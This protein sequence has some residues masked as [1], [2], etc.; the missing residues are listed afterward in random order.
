MDFNQFRHT[1]DVCSAITVSLVDDFLINYCS[2]REH[3]DEKIARR[4]GT[5]K[6]VLN[7]MPKETPFILASQYIAHRLFRADGFVKEYL[8]LDVIKKRPY[9]EIAWLSFQE[10]HPWRF[11]Y[12]TVQKNLHHEFFILRDELLSEEILVYSPGIQKI[13]LQYDNIQMFFLLIGFNG[14]CWQ[15]YG[16]LAYFC[17]MQPFDLLYFARQLKPDTD[18]M[19]SIPALIENDPIPFMLLFKGG[20]IPLTFHEKDMI[21]YNKSEFHEGAFSPESYSD[22]FLIIKKYPVYKMQLKG[23]DEHPHYCNCYYHAE[24]NLLTLTAMTDRGYSHLV[25]ILEKAGNQLPRT[26]EIRATM[27]MIYT[28]QELLKTEPEL[29][30]YEKTFVEPKSPSEESELAKIN[31]F[32]QSFLDY[33][34]A[35]RKYDL[36]ALAAAAGIDDAVARDVI[37]QFQKL[38]NRMKNK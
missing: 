6:D 17:S 2:K 20:T 10:K 25:D 35:G 1:C 15:T 9:E 12:F 33:H 3:L 28:A 38:T 14:E 29:I 37:E 4:L 34:N 36:H 32:A 21:V 30:P 23:W 24:K 11:S 8:Q 19:N 31:A 7:K 13:L 22:S 16:P 5:F 27:A 26:P 18:F